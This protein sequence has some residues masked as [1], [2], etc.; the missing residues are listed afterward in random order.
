MK[1]WTLVCG[2]LTFWSGLASPA[3]AHDYTGDLLCSV[4]D[5]QGRQTS[6]AF[7]NNTTNSA[8]TLGTMVETGV[9]KQNGQ[10]LANAPGTRPIWI[11]YTNSVNGL[12]L[13]WRQDPTW[14]IGMDAP[15]SNANWNRATAHLFHNNR[16][17][18]SGFC[19]R[20]M[21]TTVNNAADQGV[22]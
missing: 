2:A 9:V 4:T 6:W 3:F 5:A 13:K 17:I 1:L 8:N 20:E 18:A 19:A 11:I 12:T 21:A 16:M 22:D 15:T 7:A 10:E 14:M